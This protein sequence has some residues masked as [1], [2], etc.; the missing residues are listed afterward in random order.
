M[1]RRSPHY[2]TTVHI[3]NTY[4]LHQISV[5]IADDATY[6]RVREQNYK[7]GNCSTRMEMKWIQ[8]N[9]RRRHAESTILDEIKFDTS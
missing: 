2:T 8:S 7:I 9:Q 6:S 3:H 4:A 1:R 5:R